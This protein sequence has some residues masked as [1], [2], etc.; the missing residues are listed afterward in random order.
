MATLT[1]NASVVHFVSWNVKGVN[2]PVKN[3]RVLTHLKD[4]KADLVFLQE[5]HFLY[6]PPSEQAV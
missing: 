2:N 1:D 5:T 4:L 6:V 3:K